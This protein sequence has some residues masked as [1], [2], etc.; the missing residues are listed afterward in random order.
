MLAKCGTLVTP[1]VMGIDR[2]LTKRSVPPFLF[3]YWLKCSIHE[4]FKLESD[5]EKQNLRSARRYYRV[6]LVACP[7][8]K[9]PWPSPEFYQTP[10]AP[11]RAH[12][13]ETPKPSR[14]K[15]SSLQT[16]NY[17]TR[18]AQDEP[19]KRGA[20]GMRGRH[21]GR[22]GGAPRAAPATPVR[23]RAA[24]P[25]RRPGVRAAVAAP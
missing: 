12:T 22:R 25:R 1:E 2:K 6:L 7:R 13:A 8:A 21:R 4:Y 17:T 11:A 23:D 16:N 19:G 24:P 15:P 20:R 3:I 10:L 14:I 5:R 9:P 18:G